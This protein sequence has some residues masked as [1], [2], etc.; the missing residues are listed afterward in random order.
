MLI[1]LELRS[2]LLVPSRGPQ[3]AKHNHEPEACGSY[4]FVPGE[5]QD[6]ALASAGLIRG[7]VRVRC[8]FFVHNKREGEPGGSPSR[9]FGFFAMRRHLE[10]AS[11]THRV[12]GVLS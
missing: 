2:S 12:R 9:H 7:R 10:T 3:L 8:P 11:S 6:G 4:Q 5:E 1:P